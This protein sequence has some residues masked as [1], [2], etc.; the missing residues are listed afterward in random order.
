MKRMTMTKKSVTRKLVFFF[1]LFFSLF[2]QS[3][4]FF[5]FF[6]KEGGD[7]PESK[8][9]DLGEESVTTVTSRCHCLAYQ[10]HVTT[11]IPLRN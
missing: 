4:I 6:G 2:S 7:G 8:G 3:A 10:K 5:S 1:F 9:E 11:Y